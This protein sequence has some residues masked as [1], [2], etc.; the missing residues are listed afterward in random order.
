[1][2]ADLDSLLDRAELSEGERQTV[3]WL[4]KGYSLNDIADYYGKTRQN[5]EIMFRRAVKK[6]VR[7]NNQDWDEWKE[8]RFRPSKFVAKRGV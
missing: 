3:D 2:Y 8:E 1:M 6:V 7:R 4:M 5:F